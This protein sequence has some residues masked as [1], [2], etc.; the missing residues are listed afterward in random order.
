[1]SRLLDNQGNV[2]EKNPWGEWTR[3]ESWAGGPKQEMD[4]TGQPKI[5]HNLWGEPESA[6]DFWGDPI[7]SA[8]GKPLYRPASSTF[9]PSGGGGDAEAVA[10][11]LALLAGIGLFILFLY[12]IAALVSA[13]AEILAAFFKGWQS[14][15]R[16]HPRAM[17][18]VHLALGSGLMAFLANYLYLP[19]SLQLAGAVLVPLL[20]SWV[21]LTR[22]LPLVFIPINLALIGAGLWLAGEVTRSLW[23]PTWSPLT[24]GLPLVNDLSVLLAITP[25]ALWLWWQGEQRWPRAMIAINGLVLGTSLWFF[26]DRVWADWRPFWDFWMAGL[27]LVDMAAWVALLGPLTLWLWVRSTQRWPLP[28]TILNLLLFGGLLG[29]MA[30]RTQPV[31]HVTWRYWAAGLPFAP[32]PIVLVTAAPLGAWLW[33][34][35]THRWPR[36][37]IIPN[38]LLAGGFLGLV[39]DRTRP[40][41]RESWAIALGD[42]PVPV[43]LPLLLFGLPLVVWGL[44]QGSRRWPRA[45]A[46]IKALLLGLALWAVAERT[47]ALWEPAWREEVLLRWPDAPE[48]AAVVAIAPVALWAWGEAVRRGSRWRAWINSV[49]LLGLGWWAWGWLLPQGTSLLRAGLTLLPLT[50]WGWWVLLRRFPRVMWPLTLL[51]W[52]ALALIWW[53]NPVLVEAWVMDLLRWLRGEGL[54]LLP[55]GL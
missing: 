34:R 24:V 54:P 12:L 25:T 19:S 13:L 55:G 2:Y 51:P 39:A 33:D 4:W 36:L 26:T 52:A 20:W 53:L 5:R 28:F 30:D 6:R 43:E 31:W 38:L 16:R 49:V 46:P 48:P 23:E 37:F 10:A 32:F 9:G 45:F 7:R 8:E 21:W 50:V 47:R 40:L 35:G 14:L 15:A 42:L 22:H 11:A 18:I 3:Q 1:M 41:W 27:P 17:T 29:L 44:R